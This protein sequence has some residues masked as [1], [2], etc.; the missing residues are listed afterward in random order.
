MPYPV[1]R[2]SENIHRKLLK[3]HPELAKALKGQNGNNAESRRI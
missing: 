2:L 3:N 1:N